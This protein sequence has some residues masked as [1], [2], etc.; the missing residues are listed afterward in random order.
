[1]SYKIK[2]INPKKA[3]KYELIRGN[4]VFIAL[5]VLLLVLFS[6]HIHF[7]DNVLVTTD[8]MS[9]A[10]SNGDY[11]LVSNASYEMRIP[12]LNKVVRREGPERGDM[13]IF[14][15]TSR[16]AFGTG[17]GDEFSSILRVI[18][19]PGEEV[20]IIDKELFIDKK[21]IIEEYVTFD[22]EKTYPRAISPRDNIG[23]VIVPEGSYLLLGDRRD[24]VSDS[25]FFGFVSIDEIIGKVVLIYWPL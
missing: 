18:G 6:L 3:N 23:P 19:L 8:G 20:E 25:R 7:F 14:S 16:H 22:D 1:M 11:V 9:P 17:N 13:V 21:P 15:H 10:L 4:T 5:C 24:M 2:I 12:L